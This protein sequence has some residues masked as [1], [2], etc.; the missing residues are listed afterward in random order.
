MPKKGSQLKT[1]GVTYLNFACIMLTF[2]CGE[3]N[4]YV[5]P[6]QQICPPTAA[7]CVEDRLEICADDGTAIASLTC[8]LGCADNACVT[9]D[10]TPNS[11]SC[12]APK[13]AEQCSATGQSI[14]TV[15]DFGCANGECTTQECSPGLTF[16][17]PGNDKIQQCSANGQSIQ[18]LEECAFGCDTVLIQCRAAACNTG[19]VRCDDQGNPEVCNSE[20]TGF[21]PSGVTCDETCIDGECFV[22]ACI[23]GE[24]RCAVGKVEQC[25]PDGSGYA[26]W[27]ECTYGCISDGQG[28]ALCA[29][30]LPEGIICDG[31]TIQVCANPLA[32]WQDYLTCEAL[33]SCVQGNCTPVLSLAGFPTSD[34]LRILLTTAI[35]DCWIDMQLAPEGAPVTVCRALDTSNMSGDIGKNELQDW[36][37]NNQGKALTEDD[38]MSADHFAAAKTVYGCGLLDF[39]DLTVDTT[40][41]AIHAG[42]YQAECIAYDLGKEE[43]IIAPCLDLD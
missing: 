17:D 10:C 24:R 4:I 29:K 43:I 37:C 16:C 8:P 19:D 35:A 33:D 30:C 27:Q 20:Q 18:V 12:L 2:G 28:D 14:L 21:E 23:P 9:A 38:F 3:P 26:P 36:F 13:L 22:S 32:G 34:A 15:C 1:P 40:N 25:K 42:L 31:S 6:E 39:Q 41:S 5:V 11:K 7:R